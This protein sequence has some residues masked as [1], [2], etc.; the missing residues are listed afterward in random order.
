M[1]LFFFSTCD[2]RIIHEQEEK[3]M[4]LVAQEWKPIIDGL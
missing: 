4:G 2:D 3:P 1:L